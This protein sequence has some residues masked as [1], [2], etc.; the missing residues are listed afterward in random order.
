MPFHTHRLLNGLQIIGETIPSA[1]SAAV[2]FFVKT[3][4]RDESADVAGVSHFLEHMLFKGTPRRSALDVNL[5]FDRIGAN[6][7]AYT[8]EE[9]TVYY[10]AVL[11]EFLPAVVDILADILRPSLRTEDFDTEKQVILEEIKMYEDAPGSM[12]WDHA[13]RIYFADHPL[14]NTILGSM[15][16]VSALTRDQMKAYYDRR[17]VAPNIV[18]TAAGNFD[19]PAFVKL[20][21]GAC[22]HWPTGT[23][24]R[25]HLRE[26]VGAGGVHAIAKENTTQ[27]NVLVLS[28]GPPAESPL[29]YAASVLTMAV[30]DDTGSRLYWEL[31]DPGLVESAG[32][33]TDTS[34]GCGM[35]ATSFSCDPEQGAE[36]LAIVQRILADVQRDGITAEELTQAKNKVA[37]RIVRGA[38]R[39]MGRLRSIAA[40]W[41]YCDEYSDVDQEMARFDAVDLAA[42]RS[43][44]D[45]YPIDAA[46]VVGYGPLA[47]LG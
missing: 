18:V 6:Y 10:A 24:G 21:D 31:V 45:K 4:S 3:G 28:S 12:A 47:K 29:R 8:S 35:T 22:G 16:S 36:N 17:Y 1:R 32:C 15:E 41:I 13:K 23:V 20:I 25:D 19:W 7:N 34:Q 40:S 38:E 37:S 33:G 26:T 9:N 14:G 42:I 2:G 46:T 11:P 44:L 30:G 5:D 27:Q 39:P 43:Y